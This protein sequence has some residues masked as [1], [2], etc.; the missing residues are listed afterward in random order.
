MQRSALGGDG[1]RG[2]VVRG[3][4]CF[5]EPPPCPGPAGEGASPR[6]AGAPVPLPASNNDVLHGLLASERPA[7]QP[8]GC[9]M[10]VG[11]V[12]SG[13]HRAHP[14]TSCFPAC[15]FCFG[16]AVT[17]SIDDTLFATARFVP[18]MSEHSRLASSTKVAHEAAC[19]PALMQHHER[20][21][22]GAS[23]PIYTGR[24]TCRHTCWDKKTSKLTWQVA[25]SGTGKGLLEILNAPL[26]HVC[27]GMSTATRNVR[28]HGNHF[29]QKYMPLPGLHQAHP[30]KALTQ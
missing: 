29:P 19:Q 28:P 2:V 11:A 1:A 22:V 4:A 10:G 27:C 7:H 20:F 25:P 5:A 18:C 12:C 8:A 15:G 13:A 14:H 21:K 3:A 17:Q 24:R 30:R 9:F 16:L 6:Y 23:V 26:H